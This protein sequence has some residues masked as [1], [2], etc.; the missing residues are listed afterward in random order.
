V[1]VDPRNPSV[2][3][4]RKTASMASARHSLTVADGNMA[5]GRPSHDAASLFPLLPRFISGN[6]IFLLDQWLELAMA[7]LGAS[8]PF[9]SPG[10]GSMFLH[11]DAQ[12][13]ERFTAVPSPVTV[14]LAPDLASICAEYEDSIG[15]LFPIAGRDSHI[16]AA[17]SLRGLLGRLLRAVTHAKYVHKQTTLAT[18]TMRDA[19][20][21]LGCL[22]VWN[23]LD[24]IRALLLMT[25]LC[26]GHDQGELAYH[27]IALAISM[28]QTLGLHRSQ[29][30]GRETAIAELRV[31]WSVYILEKIICIEAERPSSLLH[32]ECNQIEPPDL[33]DWPVFGAAISLA[34]VQNQIS[35]KL[36]RSRRSEEAVSSDVNDL[37]WQKL[38]LVGELDKLLMRWKE[39]LPLKMQPSQYIMYS[40][41]SRLIGIAFLALQF[42]QAQFLLHRNALI[43]SSE[44]TTTVLDVNSELSSY[45]HRLRNGHKISYMAAR[46]LVNILNFSRDNNAVSILDTLYTPLLAVYGLAVHIIKNSTSGMAMADVQVTMRSTVSSD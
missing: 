45:G 42:E 27:I 11:R 15:Q 23:S 6:S 28:A 1:T 43:L 34:K 16:V 19:M 18:D 14:E 31:W 8:V 37:I 38:Q 25:L 26:R 39:A 17:G 30:D 33:A 21:Q 4:A 20:A 13:L 22:L 36:L 29:K 9:S 3:L 32:E 10:H 40:E 5:V 24:S 41:P 46:D 44:A 12:W 7:R 2:L 35:E